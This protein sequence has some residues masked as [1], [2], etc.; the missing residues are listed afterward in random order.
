MLK[1][2]RNETNSLAY[3]PNELLDDSLRIIIFVEEAKFIFYFCRFKNIW[4]SPHKYTRSK[5]GKCSVLHLSKCVFVCGE[6]YKY[7]C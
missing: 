6:F 4:D 1:F 2:P 5:G 7:A 3:K